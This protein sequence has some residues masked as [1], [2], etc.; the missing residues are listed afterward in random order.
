M[1]RFMCICKLPVDSNFLSAASSW[2]IGLKY[3]HLPQVRSRKKRIRWPVVIPLKK[4]PQDC[5]LQQLLLLKL[6]SNLVKQT[7]RTALTVTR[8]IWV[9]AL[10][11]KG[12]C[13]RSHSVGPNIH[14]LGNTETLYQDLSYDESLSGRPGAWL[15][16]KIFFCMYA[17]T[18]LKKRLHIEIQNYF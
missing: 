4:P 3:C 6:L 9:H 13:R 16:K 15:V 1:L 5:L 8:L 2:L 18:K 17:I 12:W 14:L 11:S 10:V 7:P